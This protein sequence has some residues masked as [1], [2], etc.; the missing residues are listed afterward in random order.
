MTVNSKA[1]TADVPQSRQPWW[2]PQRPSPMPYGR[3]KSA[4]DRVR[5]P[6]I[7]RSWP[8][9][10]F[11]AAP[12][13]ASVDLR[14]GNQALA[15]PMD[16]DRKYAMFRLLVDIGFK[17]IEIGYPSASDADF[18]FARRLC[19]GSA[20]P[21]D[22]TIAAFTPAR[23]E[24]IDRTFEALKGVKRGLIHLCVPT[25]PTWRSVVLGAS[26]AEVLELILS[27][28]DRVLRC[29]ETAGSG[30]VRFQ[31]SPEV[32][33]LTEP[34]YVLEVCN[35]LTQRWDA[36]A[37]RPVV[38]NLPATVEIATPNIYADQI[39]YMHRNLARR[40]HVILSVHPHNDRGTGVA[41][42]E[43]ALLAGAQR[44]E[45]CLLGNGERTGNVD[46]V[47]LAL[48][49]FSQG[50]DPMIDLSAIDDIRSRVEQC[51]RLPVHPRHPYVGDLVYTAFSGTHQDAIKKGFAKMKAEGQESGLWEVPYLPIDPS[52]V[53]RD[54]MAVVRVNSQSGKAGVAY[55]LES[56][57]GI[58]LPRPL[59]IEF[60]EIVQT[61]ANTTGTELTGDE[62]WALF[63]KEYGSGG[64]IAIE[65]VT[66]ERRGHQYLLH[67]KVGSEGGL[68]STVATGCGA[69]VVSAA[70]DLLA[71]CGVEIEILSCDLK[72]GN[73]TDGKRYI[74]ILEGRREDTVCWGV[75]IAQ[76]RAH[77]ILNAILSSNKRIS[78][79]RTP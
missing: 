71:H 35:A 49:L 65:E 43:L 42:T 10:Q 78:S 68:L 46:L 59:Q 19:L 55:L 64:S 17:E 69:E 34:D 24:L 2:N 75:G 15:D 41:A 72:A 28:A 56:L 62:L 36:C 20:V 11:Q 4:Q 39:E 74:S 45:G 66:E 76:N 60:S 9:Q 47:T 52:D 5:V 57:Y 13:W 1:G 6:R 22:V 3:Y 77:A 30:A 16:P 53:G 26:Q 44:V 23:P 40:E 67:A 8:D 33:N 38:H 14:D 61:V 51:T 73:H 25:A 32:F 18:N 27:A 79:A 12:L 37:D 7:N 54:Y 48:N 29:A 63:T 70:A 50:I 31:F 58:I 21:D